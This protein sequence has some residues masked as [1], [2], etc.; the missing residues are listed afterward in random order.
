MRLDLRKDVCETDQY[1]VWKFPGELKLIFK[2]GQFI[3]QTILIGIRKRL[4]SI[5]AN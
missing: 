4:S 3:K 1:K 5:S 2:D